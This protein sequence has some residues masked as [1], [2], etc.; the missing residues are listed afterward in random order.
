MAAMPKLYVI[1]RA[2]NAL[3]WAEDGEAMEAYLIDDL[4]RG[5]RENYGAT[6]DRARVEVTTREFAL[7]MSR[8][9]RFWRWIVGRPA[10]ER[11]VVMTA[12]GWA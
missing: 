4:V 7:P 8:V 1:H 5:A 10:P 12:K 6:I 9:R 2:V 3:W 11:F